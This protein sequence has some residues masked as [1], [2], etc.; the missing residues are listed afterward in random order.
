MCISNPSSFSHSRSIRQMVSIFVKCPNTI[1]CKLSYARDS[2]KSS[3]L[4]DKT[5]LPFI[6]IN[7]C[8]FGYFVLYNQIIYD[9]DKS[10]HSSINFIVWKKT[11][12]YYAYS[13]LFLF[14]GMPFFLSH[15]WDQYRAWR[16]GRWERACMLMTS[17]LSS[18]RN[19]K[20]GNLEIWIS[21]LGF[22]M[23]WPWL[24]AWLRLQ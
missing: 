12:P 7:G 18:S 4:H 17:Y 22:G 14:T 19:R 10:V 20:S 16:G 8:K 11:P 24:G 6:P 9:E 13:S 3:G 23:P 1:S 2:Y 15:F 5:L 21:H